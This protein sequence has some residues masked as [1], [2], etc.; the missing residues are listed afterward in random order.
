MKRMND[1][2]EL[3]AY[4]YQDAE[5]ACHTLTKTLEE[6]KE[7]DNKIKPTIEHLL[8]GYERYLEE[9]KQY[10]EKGNGECKTTG[11]MA[12]MG[13]DMGIKKEVLQDNSD[14]SMAEMLIQGI[15]M[16]TLEMEKKI[17][18]YKEDAEKEYLKFAKD[19]YKFQQDNLEALKKFL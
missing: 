7:K 17:K 8:E 5:M 6:L 11:M 10:L 14:A 13:A 2:M 12:K 3:V 4:I 18:N 9:S 19:F 15:S 1:T 16:G